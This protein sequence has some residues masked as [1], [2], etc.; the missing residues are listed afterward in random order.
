L[1]S[2]ISQ[3]L[4]SLLSLEKPTSKR[5]GSDPIVQEKPNLN[6]DPGKTNVDILKNLNQFPEEP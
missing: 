2:N 5:K 6:Q 1:K 3:L 4:F